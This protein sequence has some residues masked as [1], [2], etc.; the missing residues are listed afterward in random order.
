MGDFE[1]K[2][3]IYSTINVILSEREELK[4]KSCSPMAN[5]AFLLVALRSK[6]N[7]KC[8]KPLNWVCLFCAL[9]HSCGKRKKLSHSIKST[10]WFSFILFSGWNIQN[11]INRQFL[12]SLQIFIDYIYFC[13]YDIFL[14]SKLLASDKILEGINL[15][16]E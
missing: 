15:I 4:K 16:L 10:F 7:S 5:D 3:M 12:I 14:Y 9:L 8:P 6:V 2:R 1:L 13:K 11:E